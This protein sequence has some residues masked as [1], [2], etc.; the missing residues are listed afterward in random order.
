MLLHAAKSSSGAAV[1]APK[2]IWK[3]EDLRRGFLPD[4]AFRQVCV[5]ATGWCHNTSNFEPVVSRTHAH[6][7]FGGS[8]FVLSRVEDQPLVKVQLLFVDGEGGSALA[9]LDRLRLLLPGAL[10]HFPRLACAIQLPLGGSYNDVFVHHDALDVVVT[11]KQAVFI[12]QKL[13]APSEAEALLEVWQPTPQD[14]WHVFISYRWGK[15]DSVMADVLFDT[16]ATH[17]ISGVPLWVFQDKRR[18]RGGQ[19]LDA[20]CTALSSALS[21]RSFLISST[22]WRP[23]ACVTS[24]RL[25]AVLAHQPSPPEMCHALRIMSSK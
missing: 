25:F 12:G 17:D 9:V 1:A 22:V 3:T 6:V 4:G 11:G 8:Q 21:P 2:P 18:L 24:T 15:H 5:A 23:S 13:L 19:R 16:L 10:S 20:A 14:K 7:A